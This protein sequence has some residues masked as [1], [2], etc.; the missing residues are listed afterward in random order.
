V[1][2]RV[3]FLKL[4]FRGDLRAEPDARFVFGDNALRVGMGGQAGSMRGE[5]NAI[6]VATKRA[7]DMTDDDFFADDN[8][9]DL[10]IV[11]EDID[12]VIA[13]WLEGR[14]IYLPS[15][16]IGT[17]LFPTADAGAE[18]SPAHHQPFPRARR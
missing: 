3:E 11:D 13:A 8:A 16:G 4:I 14:T 12:R 2:G 9:A 1:S 6:G 17:G 15:D 5:P 7:P 18:T 10:A